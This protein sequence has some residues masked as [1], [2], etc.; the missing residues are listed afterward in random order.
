MVYTL[1]RCPAK[2]DSPMP[3]EETCAMVT[4][5]KH[6]LHTHQLFST[7]IQ[8]IP[9]ARRANGTGYG[10][11]GG[12]RGH[13]PP[14]PSPAAGSLPPARGRVRERGAFRQLRD[15]RQQN[16]LPLTSTPPAMGKGEY[17][18]SLAPP[19]RTP[20]ERKNTGW[21][22]PSRCNP[23]RICPRTPGTKWRRA[24]GLCR[25]RRSRTGCRWRVSLPSRRGPW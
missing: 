21:W 3:W 18:G 12:V 9:S 20:R 19:C 4:N 11:H 16:D 13:P 7:R 6:P 15:T 23:I 2:E 1:L 5:R 17:A 22:I 8:I 14:Q 25:R 24:V 10:T